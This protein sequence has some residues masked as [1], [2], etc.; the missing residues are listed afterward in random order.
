MTFIPKTGSFEGMKSLNKTAILNL[1]RL[2]GPISRAQIAKITKLTPPT[3]GTIVSEFLEEGILREEA[4]LGKSKGGRKPIM[5]SIN[6]SRFYVIGVYGAAEVV[7]TV[8]AT[9]DGKVKHEVNQPLTTLPSKDEFLQIITKNIHQVLSLEKAPAESVVG[10]GVAMHGLVDTEKGI[11]VF[12][13]HLNLENIPLK[14]V[15]EHEFTVPV[16][17][18]NDVRALTLAESWYGQGQAVSNFIC[19]SVGLGVGSG[20]VLN[21]KIFRGPYHAAGE[22]GHTTVDVSGPRCHC[23][24]HGC[25]EAYA[26]EHAILYRIKKG[27]R[28]GRS[29]ILTE[30][31]RGDENS[32][33]IEM[34][35]K[36][37][38]EGDPHAVETL[39]DSGRYLGIAIANVINILTP[40]RIILEGRIFEAGDLILSPLR[41]MV[42]KGS[43]RHTMEKTK[44]ST[45]SLGKDGM[46][47]GA[48]TLV[49][50]NI[51][52]P[53][54]V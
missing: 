3:V 10:I 54:E 20:M 2:Q 14:E 33:T 5:L 22:I 44:I 47:T 52:I 8:I 34:V 46:L 35:F 27:I 48:F 31:L 12:A 53:E 26:S 7:R 30:W 29:T 24:N 15:L 50:R 39:E 23:G 40:S 4:D 1:V 16:F 36:A 51:F 32:L 49:L 6:A 45:S 42:E 18:E 28:M 17:V 19:I 9:L 41:Q 13:P 21:N 38:A 37:A 25:L 43:L 11:S